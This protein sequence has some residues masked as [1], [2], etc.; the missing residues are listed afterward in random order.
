M[1]SL[2]ERIDPLAENNRLLN[3]TLTLLTVGTEGGQWFGYPLRSE[4]SRL[5]SLTG[6]ELSSLEYKGG[7]KQIS[8]ILDIFCSGSIN[9]NHSSKCL[10]LWHLT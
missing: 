4:S 9:K 1:V 7:C 10:S 5:G 8:H 3:D 2:I 6:N